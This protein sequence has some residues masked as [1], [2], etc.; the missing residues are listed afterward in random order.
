VHRRVFHLLRAKS[1]PRVFQHNRRSLRKA[2]RWSDGRLRRPAVVAA[3]WQPP[4][5]LCENSRH[6][7]DHAVRR[8]VVPTSP[9]R[10]SCRRTSDGEAGGPRSEASDYVERLPSPKRAKQGRRS[11][12][13]P[14]HHDPSHAQHTRRDAGRS[15]R[16][17]AS[18]RAGQQ[19]SG[20]GSDRVTASGHL[21]GVAWRAVAPRTSVP[22]EAFRTEPSAVPIWAPESAATTPRGKRRPG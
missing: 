14:S 1:A 20:V 17:R 11:P 6:V 19:K 2:S 15:T 13:S 4:C 18:T 10:R 9:H 21:F 8:Q 3:R 16:C 7:R 12:S 5:H 22:P